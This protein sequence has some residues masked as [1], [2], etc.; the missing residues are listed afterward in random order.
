MTHKFMEWLKLPE[1]VRIPVLGGIWYRWISKKENAYIRKVQL[2][3]QVLN[4][5]PREEKV[6]ASLTSFPARIESTHLAIKSIMLQDF[7]PDEIILWLSDKQF[8]GVEIPGSLREL[9]KKGLQIRFCEDLRGHKKYFELVKAQQPNELILT[10]DDDIIYPPDSISKVV[11]Y[12]E[13][14]PNAIITNR[15]SEITFDKTGKL[16][17]HSK[18]RLLSAYG[19]KTPKKL[20]FISNG[21]G[22][23]IPYN[24][25][26]KDATNSDRIKELALSV[27]DLWTTIMAILA[28]TDVVKTTRFHKT[29]VTVEDSQKGQLATEN[30]L[31]GGDRHDAVIAALREVYPQLDTLLVPAR[32]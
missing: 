17:S 31:Q 26:Y 19:V 1:S 23:L 3:E 30:L 24:T 13:K 32:K 18:W 29:Y 5:E 16:E 12:H 25:L 7:K 14:Y 20:V 9:E 27:D 8:E 21:S 22:I 11:K 15:G 6:I 2:P 28:Q 10:F 4:T